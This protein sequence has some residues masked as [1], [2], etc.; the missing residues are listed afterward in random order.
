MLVSVDKGAM[1]SFILKLTL[2]NLNIGYTEKV[3]RSSKRDLSRNFPFLTGNQPTIEIKVVPGTT[4]F[5]T[6]TVILLT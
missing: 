2:K 3:I 4:S 6:L 1:A 5:I